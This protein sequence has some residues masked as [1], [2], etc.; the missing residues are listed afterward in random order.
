MPFING[1]YYMNPAYGRAVEAARVFEYASHHGASDQRDDGSHWVTI[2]G[3]HVLIQKT[4]TK[5]TP[6][7]S[8]RDRAYLDKY[9]DAVAA[10]A[11]V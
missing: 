1:K 2:N 8:A 10:L 7:I 3:Q 5:Q 11:K 4:Q 6:Q 9:Y